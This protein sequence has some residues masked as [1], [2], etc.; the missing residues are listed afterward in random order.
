MT[1][2][3]SCHSSSTIKEQFEA[4]T[5][6]MVEE[7]FISIQIVYIKDKSLTAHSSPERRIIHAISNQTPRQRLPENQIR[8]I[9]IFQSLLFFFLCL[10]SE[11]PSTS[12]C[13]LFFF[14]SPD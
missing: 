9:R 10:L 3:T 1:E 5:S 8:Q 7:A 11:M 4:H 14:P 2:I 6:N 12:L 13:L